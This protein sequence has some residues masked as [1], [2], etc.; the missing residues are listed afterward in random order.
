MKRNIDEDIERFDT[1]HQKAIV[2]LI[3]THGI[4]VDKLNIIFKK[5]NISRQQF[6]ILRILRMYHP[7]SANV[8]AIK[9]K[10]VV[11]TSDV[12]RIIERMKKNGLVLQ[13]KKS[14]DLREKFLSIT[15]KGLSIVED[16]YSKQDYFDNLMKPLTKQELKQL[17]HILNKI[18]NNL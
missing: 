2:N 12:S 11:K 4:I 16:I 14:N 13:E 15:T 8:S 6:N 7:D 5:Y 10:M 3:Y 1:I 17:N 18:R 9:D